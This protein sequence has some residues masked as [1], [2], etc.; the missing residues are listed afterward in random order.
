MRHQNKKNKVSLPSGRREAV[1]KGLAE[2]LIIY[3]KIETTE[4]RAKA[5]KT[6]MDKLINMAKKESKMNAIREV[7]KYINDKNASKKLFEVIVKKC[8]GK[9]SGY[10][11]VVKTGRR[12]GDSAHMALIEII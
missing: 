7:S 3:E 6:F 11:R 2:S 1:I 4:G 12:A 10:T 9:A 5:L 8:E